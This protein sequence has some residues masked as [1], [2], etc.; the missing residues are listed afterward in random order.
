MHRRCF[1]PP[2]TLVPPCS[3][4]VSYFWGKRWTNSS[5]WASLHA[6]TSSSSVA[7]WLPHRRLSLMVP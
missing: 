3:M 4:Y 7:F 2:E 1:W 6:S 5:A